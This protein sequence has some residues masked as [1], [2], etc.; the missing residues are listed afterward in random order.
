MRIVHFTSVHPRYDIRI[1]VKQCVT[2]AAAGHDVTLVVADGEGHEIDRAVRFYDI[3][4]RGRSRLRRMTYTVSRLYKT[5]AALRPDIAHFHDPELIPVALGL[6]QKGIKVIYDV[7]EDVPL[8]ILAKHWIPPWLRP[9]LSRCVATL[10]HY[11][12][13]RFDA[14]VVATPTI[15][16]RFSRLNSRVID[17][18]NYPILEEWEQTVDWAD[19]R[20]EVCYIG[21]IARIRG[22]QQ[23]ITALLSTR[24]RLNLAGPWSE[25]DLRPLL[26]QQP[27]W[28]RVNEQG[29]VDRAGI[30]KILARSKIGLVTLLPS[31][32]YVESLPIKLF[33]YMAAGVPVIASDFPLWRT[34]VE[35]AGCGLLVDP[36]DPSAIAAAIEQLLD[37]EDRAASMGHAGQRAVR[38][39]Y[40]WA[41]QADK[42]LQLYHGL[43]QGNE[44]DNNRVNTIQQR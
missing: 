38:Q 12:A 35:T 4:L 40:S 41:R 20:N 16:Q 28:S 37:D 13:R 19:R 31:P 25:P 7:H 39:N 2:L 9:F 1:F 26:T 6:K 15:R 11:A 42:L 18:C 10:E 36:A 3:G 5:V 44:R 27:G 24:V 14:I 34:I 8:Q 43:E 21:S 29:V 30:V 17:V 22:I 32:N 23:I 33:E